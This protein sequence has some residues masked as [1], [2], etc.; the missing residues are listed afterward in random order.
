MYVY[1]NYL[2]FCSG[3]RLGTSG[4]TYHGNNIGVQTVK[5]VEAD[6]F[7]LCRRQAGCLAFA[8]YESN[9]KCILKGVLDPQGKEESKDFV[10][11]MKAG[12]NIFIDK[13]KLELIQRV[14]FIIHMFTGSLC[15]GG[16]LNIHSYV[17]WTPESSSD[18]YASNT[19]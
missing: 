5:E 8:F 7:D 11:G 1:S 3:Y 13:G 18:S 19:I 17:T 2:S 14:L 16:H 12:Q 4:Y 9:M 10:W 6:C 15:P